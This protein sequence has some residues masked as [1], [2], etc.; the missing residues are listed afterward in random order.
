MRFYNL[1][2]KQGHLSALN[3][4]GFCYKH[5]FGVEKDYKEVV[6]LY[7]LAA[8]QGSASARYNLGICYEKGE[9]VKKDLEEAMRWYRLAADQGNQQARKKLFFCTKNVTVKPEVK[10]RKQKPLMQTVRDQLVWK[11]VE[12]Q[13]DNPNNQKINKQNINGG[14]EVGDLNINLDSL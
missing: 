11:R 12:P 10:E 8:D 3:S 2:V 7:Q 5:G 13:I 6:R 4:L 14:S 9:G 1:A